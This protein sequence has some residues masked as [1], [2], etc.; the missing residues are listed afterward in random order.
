[1]SSMTVI[2]SLTITG[3]VLNG[4]TCINSVSFTHIDGK[5]FPESHTEIIAVSGPK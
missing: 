3:G 1:M 4:Y 2:V 5:G